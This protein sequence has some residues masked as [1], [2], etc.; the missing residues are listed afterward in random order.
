MKVR[1]W[2][3][4]LAEDE[5]A[6]EALKE[7]C[8]KSKIPLSVEYIDVLSSVDRAR[9]AQVSLTPLIDRVE[10]LP[11]LRLIALNGGAQSALEKLTS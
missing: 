9:E 3:S 4:S 6:I 2:G 10:P 8:Q 5:S 11:L 7:R 1:Y